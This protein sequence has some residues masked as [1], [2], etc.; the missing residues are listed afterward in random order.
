MKIIEKP[1]DRDQLRSMSQDGRERVTS[2]VAIPWHELPNRDQD[3]FEKNLARR[4]TGTRYGLGNVGVRLVG[5][6]GQ[7]LLLEVSGDVSMLLEDYDLIM[8]AELEE[9]GDERGR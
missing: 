8:V 5:V 9:A 2:V 7:D 1:H 6:L 4:L 3:A